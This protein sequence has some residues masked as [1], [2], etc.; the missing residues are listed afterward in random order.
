MTS[1]SFISVGWKESGPKLLRATSNTLVY[2]IM[3]FSGLGEKGCGRW[4]GTRNQVGVAC[5][6]LQHKIILLKSPL[7]NV[8]IRGDYSSSSTDLIGENHSESYHLWCLCESS[9]TPSI[10]Q[11]K[12]WDF[13]EYT[14]FLYVFCFC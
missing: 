6:N 9:H 1:H 14:L 7:N 5:V 13:T 11:N 10:T 3:E 2:R 4:M 12:L 8:G